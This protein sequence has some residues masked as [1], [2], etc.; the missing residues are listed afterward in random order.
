MIFFHAHTD[1]RHYEWHG[2]GQTA[3][4]AR[5]GLLTCLKE[6]LNPQNPSYV[7]YGF[8]GDHSPVEDIY[9]RT[10]RTGAG[11]ID[12]DGEEENLITPR[13]AHNLRQMRGKKIHADAFDSVL[14]IYHVF[15]DGGIDYLDPEQL[16]SIR[17]MLR[18]KR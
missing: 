5:H 10:V 16:Q 4:E 2:Y 11:Y 18:R 1:S 15:D 8:W 12:S 14:R 6:H 3:T 9:V 13:Q 17:I 7:A